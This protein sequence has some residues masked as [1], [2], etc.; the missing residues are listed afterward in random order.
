MTQ[1]YYTIP[2]LASKPLLPPLSC[3]DSLFSSSAERIENVSTT[4]SLFSD[5]GIVPTL[6]EM[7]HNQ[8]SRLGLLHLYI[9]DFIVPSRSESHILYVSFKSGVFCSYQGQSHTY[10][11]A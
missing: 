9:Q 2:V 8:F 5:F 4:I 1:A 10:G 11:K 7:R 3:R 6:F